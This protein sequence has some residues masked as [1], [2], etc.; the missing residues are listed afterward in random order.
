MRHTEPIPCHG[1]RCSPIAGLVPATHDARIADTDRDLGSTRDR[2]RSVDSR[3]IFRIIDAYF[4]PIGIDHVEPP[5]TLGERACIWW[6][7]TPV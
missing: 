1:T 7:R 6:V 4:K 2:M 5:I 3:A